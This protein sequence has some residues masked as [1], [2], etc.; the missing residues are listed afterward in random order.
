M[1]FSQYILSKCQT[2]SEKETVQFLVEHYEKRILDI[3][4]QYTKHIEYI[5]DSHDGRVSDLHKRLKENEA[6]KE[7]ERVRTEALEVELVNLR[8]QMEEC[9][10]RDCTRL[11][12][13]QI[14]A[15]RRPDLV[16]QKRKRPGQLSQLRLAQTLRETAR[17]TVDATVKA[18]M[19][20]KADEICTAMT[21][22][23]IVTPTV[24]DH[25]Q[26]E[27]TRKNKRQFVQKIKDEIA[28]DNMLRSK[29][30]VPRNVNVVLH[31]QDAFRTGLE[32]GKVTVQKQAVTANNEFEELA[33]ELSDRLAESSTDFT[34]EDEAQSS[35]Y[36]AMKIK[37]R[38]DD[39]RMEM[40][41]IHATKKFV[42]KAR[43]LMSES[44]VSADEM[45]HALAYKKVTGCPALTG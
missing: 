35:E 8:K 2:K 14:K 38:I 25:V 17:T 12:V 45:L 11:T 44:D 31:D 7:Y 37:E 39:K 5:T 13:E 26:A 15:M 40:K 28:I 9:Q 33:E 20:T 27:T 43:H 19:L 24:S 16:Q 6:D 32:K 21:E 10:Q 3:H 29:S 42:E 18:K 41:T 22:D 36:L 30:T 34:S 23:I 4:V 1:E